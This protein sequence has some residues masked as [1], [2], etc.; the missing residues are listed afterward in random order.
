MC[1]ILG[2][3]NFNGDR[4]SRRI[5]EKMSNAIIHRGPDDHAYYFHSNI[6]FG[7]RRLSII[8]L[9]KNIYPLTNEDSTIKVIFNGEIYNFSEIRKDLENKGH[10]FKTNCD[11]EV[12]VHAYEEYGTK[13]VKKFNGMFAF[14][15]FDVNKKTLFIARDRLGIKPIYYYNDENIFVFSSEI[16]SIIK[17]DH[18]KKDYN[19]EALIEYLAFQNILDDKTFFKNIKILSPGNF[20]IIK[21]NKFLIKKYWDL[22]FSKKSKQDLN[23]HVKDFKRIFMASVKRHMISDV[24]LGSYLS[25]GL[26][27]TSVATEASKLI[28]SRLLTF[29]GYFNDPDYDEILY[30]R[31]V[32]DRIKSNRKE[33]L[34][35]PEDFKKNISR[36]IYHL[37][38]PR[39]A[40]STLSSFCV[41]RLVRKYAKVVLTGHGGDEL[42]A[43]YPVYKSALIK[44]FIKSD[45]KLAIK[46]I[47]SIKTKEMP[48]IAYFFFVKNAEKGLFL[49]FDEKERKK[50]LTQDFYDSVS[51]NPIKTIDKIVPRGLDKI[52]E[53]QYLYI[54]TYLHSLLIVEDKMG[55]ANS[56]E[57]RTPICDNEMVDLSLR[58]PIEDK[59]H[60]GNLK[61]IIKESMKHDLPEILYKQGKKGFPTPLARWFKKELKPFIYEILLD[62]KT[63]QRGI[64]NMDYVKKL[65]DNHCSS[66]SINI[67]LD[68][69]NA[70][71]IWSLIC[72]EL[73][74]RVFIDN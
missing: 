22:D 23:H 3:M 13:C 28:K 63:K 46:L 11:G 58:I 26:D 68:I 9:K 50:L 59:L 15:L 34:I 38:E 5:I 17:H 31:A 52:D 66:R 69:Y 61:Y 47:K 54:K 48:R 19:K 70:N 49:L 32:A 12:I 14:A 64:F 39:A 37:D 16:K 56:I 27:S 72:I 73:W 8:D 67:D 62:D 51:F 6:G 35:K 74:F 41:S 21:N 1:G 71:K 53:I 40:M 10:V 65:L 60:D 33:V 24:P 20:I 57:S 4:V 36:I 42:F 2:V 7:F 45:K 30:S 43:G 55:M 44:K 25:G 18:I 29:T